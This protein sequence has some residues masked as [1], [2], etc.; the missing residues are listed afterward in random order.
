M[1]TYK[2]IFGQKIKSLS[3]DPPAAIGEGQIWYNDTSDTFKTATPTAAWASAPALST[4][5]AGGGSGGIPTAAWFAGGVT[6][7]PSSTSTATEEYDGSSWTA[8]GALTN[9]RVYTGGAGPLTAGIIVAGATPFAPS[10]G[11]GQTAVE[12]Y[13]GEAWTAE[14]A[15]PI[16]LWSNTAF[17]TE[18]AC[19]TAGANPDSTNFV[20]DYDGSSWTTGGTMN[21]IRAY[22]ASA[23]TQTAGGVMGG[24]G[25]Y[26][27]NYEQYDGS[28]WTAGPALNTARFYSGAGGPQTASINF[29]G[30]TPAPAAAG[31]T[32]LFDGTSWTE[33]A[34]L[35]TARSLLGSTSSITSNTAAL[36]FGGSP[37]GDPSPIHNATEEYTNVAA[38]KT[39]TAS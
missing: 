30:E 29:G 10:P 25:P 5:R 38:V 31:E 4:A 13:N 1:A 2:E 35:A 28:S 15:T 22:S 37:I 33:G 23:G 6:S 16:G 3:A 11:G 9:A 34:D 14:T 32:E 7:F 20:F 27:T 17:G 19:T 8:G 39:I 12:S 18:A 36:A 24:Y 21:A 26:A